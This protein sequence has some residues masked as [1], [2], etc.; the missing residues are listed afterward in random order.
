MAM[1]KRLAAWHVP[2]RPMDL[3]ALAMDSL[4]VRS[5]SRPRRTRSRRHDGT[6]NGWDTGSCP[7]RH[8]AWDWPT[9]RLGRSF[10]TSARDIDLRAREP[11]GPR[12]VRLS[13]RSRNQF[14][15]D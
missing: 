7:T 11:N 12:R 10:A 1:E 3:D 14:F 8:P 6:A 13:A 4:Y 15:A 5:Y 9:P 2:V